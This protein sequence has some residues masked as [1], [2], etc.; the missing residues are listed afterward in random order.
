[1]ANNRF[2]IQH[3]INVIDKTIDLQ[4]AS[5]LKYLES[6]H[7]KIINLLSSLK[8][9]PEFIQF[10]NAYKYAGNN[11]K[12]WYETIEKAINKIELFHI[13]LLYYLDTP[14]YFVS[15]N[16]I[17]HAASQMKITD[18]IV[19]CRDQCKIDDNQ[20]EKLRDAVNKLIIAV[21]QLDSLIEKV[22]ATRIGDLAQYCELEALSDYAALNKNQNVEPTPLKLNKA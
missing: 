19:T 13:Q 18:S 4:K 7:D 6:E 20:N 3:Q 21:D 10:H 17:V 9:D 15:S 8:K 1:M 5:Q 11:M 2:F 16:N 14:L 22:H 12:I